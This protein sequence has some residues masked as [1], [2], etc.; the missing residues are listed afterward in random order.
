MVNLARGEGRNGFASGDTY[1]GIQNVIGY[2]GSDSEKGDWLQ[3]N[4]ADNY[5]AG[6]GG[7]DAIFG[8]LGADTISGGAGWDYV[9]YSSS[10]EGVTINLS[11]NINT[12]GEAEGD[13]L[14]GLEGIWGSNNADHFT[15]GI[16]DVYFSAGG[17]DDIIIN[18]AGPLGTDGGDGADT[19][20][21]TAEGLGHEFTIKHFDAA[22]GDKVDLSELLGA[23]NSDVH[24]I[25]DFLRFEEQPWGTYLALD[26]NGGGNNFTT[27]ALFM[28]SDSELSLTSL[29]ESSAFII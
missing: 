12:G 28:Q 3:G 11:S 6:L 29:Y 19:F 26:A 4:N 23:F 21:F 18:G 8:G 7:N 17:G 20:V 5:L 10:N 27:I 16:D 25:E 15:G 2:D 9:S 22:E 13:K 14:Y 24:S 1:E